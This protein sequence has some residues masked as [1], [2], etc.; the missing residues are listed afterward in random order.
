VGCVRPDGLKAVDLERRRRIEE[1]DAGLRYPKRKSGE[2][3]YAGGVGH[4]G[5]VGYVVPTPRETSRN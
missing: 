2:G 3:A 1:R 5:F 4:A